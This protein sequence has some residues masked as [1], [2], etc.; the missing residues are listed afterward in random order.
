MVSWKI[1]NNEKE[2]LLK[3]GDLPTSR[4]FGDQVDE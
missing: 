2:K 3:K 1:E 4:L